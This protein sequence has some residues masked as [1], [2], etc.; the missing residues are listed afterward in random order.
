[1]LVPGLDYSLDGPGST[2]LILRFFA[3]NKINIDL[4]TYHAD[5]S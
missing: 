1:M 5:S 2:E 3:K 4:F